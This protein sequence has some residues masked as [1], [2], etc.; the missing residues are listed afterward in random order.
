MTTNLTPDS[1]VQAFIALR[2]RVTRFCFEYRVCKELFFHSPDRTELLNRSAGPLFAILFDALVH[3]LLLELAVMGDP[4]YSNGDIKKTNL[5]LRH[6]LALA[7]LR[8]APSQSGELAQ[9]R[10]AINTFCKDL[11][12]IGKHRN[13]RI[14]HADA[15]TVLDPTQALPIVLRE[16]L[17]RL[18]T[19]LFTIMNDLAPFFGETDFAFDQ[20]DYRQGADEIVRL[21]NQGFTHAAFQREVRAS[22]LLNPEKAELLRHA[23]QAAFLY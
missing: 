18:A 21:L 14:A 7:E 9:V 2:N 11:E 4:P 13:K 22:N 1:D 3:Q 5:S 19:D 17:D 16:Q 10:H 12:P 8:S 6:V 23:V 20:P 15:R